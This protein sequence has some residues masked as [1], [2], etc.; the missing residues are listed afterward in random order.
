VR[1]LGQGSI[2]RLA[3]MSQDPVRNALFGAAQGRGLLFD[4][5]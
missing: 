3:W 1:N 4:P 5:V 2:G